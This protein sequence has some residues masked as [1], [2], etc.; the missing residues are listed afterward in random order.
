MKQNVPQLIQK[1]TDNLAVEKLV[2]TDVAPPI[3]DSP[4][5]ENHR[6]R[7]QSKTELRQ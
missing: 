3:R 6:S 2:V 5:W 4:L 7:V 1:K